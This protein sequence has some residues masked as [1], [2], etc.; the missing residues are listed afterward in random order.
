MSFYIK[1]P[2]RALS[3]AYYHPI[4]AALRWCGL[5]GNEKM[6]L[7]GVRTS[8]AGG[9]IQGAPVLWLFPCLKKY[10]EIIMDAI[11]HGEIPSGRDGK[12]VKAG[13][14]IA[15]DE[16]TVRHRDLRE[17]IVKFHPYQR[18][19][20]LFDQFERQTHWALNF[21]KIR[22]LEADQEALRAEIERLQKSNSE[23]NSENEA[24]QTKLK[25]G[26]ERPNE[27]L[28]TRELNSLLVMFAAVSQHYGFNF[29]TRGAANEIVNMANEVGLDISNDTVRKYLNQIP[30]VVEARSKK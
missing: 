12:P 19:E 2:S 14:D 22:T 1:G 11:H 7:D 26:R 6:I 24:L 4:E 5:I 15:W 20:F 3:K 16:L 18:P 21:D 13:E 17:W 30:D 27:G 10:T 23:L 29:S 8:V 9:F 25:P 28:G